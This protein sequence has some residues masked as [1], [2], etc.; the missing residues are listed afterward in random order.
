VSPGVVWRW[1]KALDVKRME[2][3]GSR[4]L[5]LAA[6]AKGAD[7]Q[8]GVELPPEQV[9]RRRQT[10]VEQDLGRNLQLGYH[11]ECWT[12]E[13]VALLGK[14]PD[15]EIARRTGRT[16]NAVRQKR[17][18]LGLPNP[19]ARAGAY[20]SPP[21]TEEEDDVLRRLSPKEAAEQTGR[22]LD[23]VY[24]RRSA[25]GLAPARRGPKRRPTVD[26]PP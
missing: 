22:T 24:G 7:V 12:D 11:G 20:G 14:I 16:L 6:S 18:V 21:W 2:N 13:D 4:R 3:P 17:V 25:L 5:T 10:A 15:E 8:R 9:E 1:R 26:P 23:A 19:T